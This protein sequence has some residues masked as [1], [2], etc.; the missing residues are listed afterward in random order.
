MR[1]LMLSSP[2]LKG[3]ELLIDKEGSMIKDVLRLSIKPI[4]NSYHFFTLYANS[5]GIIAEFLVPLLFSSYR[6]L[7]EVAPV[8]EEL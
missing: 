1:F 2:V 3:N 6:L 8:S 7:E 5:D 4:W